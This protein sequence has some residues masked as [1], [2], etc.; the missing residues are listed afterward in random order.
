MDW[1]YASPHPIVAMFSYEASKE[2]TEVK[3]TH[4]G[5]ALIQ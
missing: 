1:I 3:W 2:V 4:K 5:E